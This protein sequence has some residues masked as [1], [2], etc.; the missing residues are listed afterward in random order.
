MSARLQE[1]C[2]APASAVWKD[3]ENRALNHKHLRKLELIDLNERHQSRHASEHSRAAPYHPMYAFS[4]PMV[5]RDMEKYHQTK[6]RAYRVWIF[7]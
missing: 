1:S 5:R 3:A 7:R 6:L 2:T 4:G